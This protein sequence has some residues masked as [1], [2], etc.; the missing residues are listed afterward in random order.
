[1]LKKSY[2]LRTL[3]QFS[4]AMVLLLA[5]SILG[6]FWLVSEYQ[7]HL[8]TLAEVRND[9]ITTRKAETKTLVSLLV[10]STELRRTA[11]EKNLRKSVAEAVQ[12]GW[13]TASS[14]YN[15]SKGKLPDKEIQ[16]LIIDTLTAQRFLDG[17]GYYWIHNTSHTLI[18]HP[19]RTQ[20][21]GQNDQELTDSKGQKLIQS[22]IQKATTYPEGAYVT[23]YWNRPEVDESLHLEKGQKKIAFLKF[24]APYNWVIGVGDYVADAEEEAKQ[25]AITRIGA[26]HYGSKGYVFIH[27]KE[28]ICLNH[29]NKELI[30][31]NRWELKDAN[32]MKVVQ[33]LD[34]TG[35]T[36]G[37]GFLEYIASI[38]P[39][40]G[41][42]ARKISYVKSVKGWDWVIG[43][44]VYLDDVEL[45]I[46]QYREDLLK[47][48]RQK[49]MTTI[50]ILSVAL[51]FGLW[52]GRRL[53]HGLL[54]ELSIFTMQSSQGKTE[55]IDTDKLRIRELRAIANEANTILHEKEKVQVELD[56]AKRM[57]TVGLMAGG[58]AHDL[59]NLLSGVINYPE[60][61]LLNL[62]QDSNLRDPLMR[63]QE[64]GQRAAA[65][66]SDLLT[67]ARG[68]ASV[69]EIIDLNTAI[70][71]YLQTPHHAK[72]LSQYPG[73]VCSVRAHDAPLPISCSP[74]H[75]E[76]CIA[77]LVTNAAEAI[78]NVG[79]IILSTGSIQ[80]DESIPHLP[81]LQS[82]PY[83]FITVSDNG[84][85]I[86]D[87]D[88][89]HIFEPFYTRKTMGRSGTGLGLTV[90]WNT[91]IDHQ[92]GVSVTSDGNGSRFNLFFPLSPESATTSA[93]RVNA[94]D[95]K[96]CGNI[97]V[98]DDEEIQ[99]DIAS[100]IL[101]VLGYTVETVSS[102][103]QAI[104][105]LQ[106]HNVDL[107]VLD[108]V[109]PKGMNGRETYEAIIRIKPAQKAVIVSG[110]AESE[111]VRQAC[112]LGAGKFLK[113]PYNLQQ[114]GQVVKAELAEG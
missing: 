97:L 87:E 93:E 60:L 89:P 56:K 73:I 70:N 15:Q 40:T 85:G 42:P 52:L 95:L 16:Q 79:S 66:V 25:A 20:S 32:G 62:P 38:D 43:S 113:K 27:T 28:G 58:V 3:V 39:E 103:E 50:A 10:E 30:G 78:K 110:Y 14:I 68:I 75:V 35:R 80:V 84:K 41:V 45:I 19:F 44:G 1:M 59:N 106:E 63:I 57:E 34:R 108:M 83:A 72:L 99:R 24:F 102:G 26:V 21:I 65:I 91:M 33:E 12:N 104:A 55:F 101:T 11:V 54:K 96:G 61:I 76:K 37:G 94:Q 22:F 86:R 107:V 112:R 81:Q 111:D 2:S 48:L 31:T 18:A 29:I 46:K 92:G 98:V 82:G 71:D 5:I 53:I 51:I 74:P 17:R 77:N 13:A 90:V 49:I 109:M 6:I 23:Y 69:R 7:N 105:Y 67:V 114:L 64:S 47:K 9:Y 4:I 36:A 100:A 8:E 88:L